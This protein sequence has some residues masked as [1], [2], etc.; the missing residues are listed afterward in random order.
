MLLRR[1]PKLRSLALIWILVS[2]GSAAAFKS[3]SLLICAPIN[4]VMLRED[5]NRPSLRR[6]FKTI[7]TE[8]SFCCA[9]PLGFEIN[10]QVRRQKGLN[11]KGVI[12]YDAGFVL[13]WCGL[14]VHI[15]KIHVIQMNL[16]CEYMLP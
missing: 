6:T 7:V 2:G 8:I 10:I 15:K 5:W 16:A 1:Y 14:F 11:R 13:G 3:N 9:N 12:G 4:P